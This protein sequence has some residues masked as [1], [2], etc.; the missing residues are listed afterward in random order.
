MRGGACRSFVPELR[1]FESALVRVARERSSP[2]DMP[3][4]KAKTE[5]TAII[6]IDCESEEEQEQEKAKE[7]EVPD[8]SDELEIVQAPTRAQEATPTQTNQVQAEA[9]DDDEDVVMTST[10]MASL[11]HN[12]CNCPMYV[13]RDGP[14]HL[15]CEKCYCFV[16]DAPVSDCTQWLSHCAAHDKD[17]YWVSYFPIFC[18]SIIS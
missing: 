16:C 18:F 5:D 14:N 15:H 12:R 11:P 13:F 7:E 10:A 9:E 8:D 17:Q 6:M 3:G 1:Q 4:K 2:P